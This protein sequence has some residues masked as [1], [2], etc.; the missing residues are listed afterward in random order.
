MINGIPILGHQE[1]GGIT[2]QTVRR[3]MQLQGTMQPHQ[4]ISLL[5]MGGEH[6]RDGRPQRPHP[7]RLPAAVR[8]RTRSSASRRSRCSSPASGP[9]SSPASARSTT[10]SCRPSR[11]STRCRP[12][13]ALEQRPRR[14]VARR[15][16]KARS[17]SSSSSSASCSARPT[18]A[19][20]CGPRRTRSWRACWC[21]GRSARRSG[22]DS[23]AAAAASRVPSRPRHGRGSPPCASSRAAA[24]RG[25]VRHP[26]PVPTSRVTV[27]R[28]APFGSDEAAAWLAPRRTSTPSSPPP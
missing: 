18:G 20:S 28:A 9:T 19:T 2:E 11:P 7:R 15:A 23:A 5:D 25:R 3:L 10:R 24:A 12:D 6:V 26:E 8:R 22:G 27:A 16:P 13:E 21:C 14:R 17:A 1:P 4:I